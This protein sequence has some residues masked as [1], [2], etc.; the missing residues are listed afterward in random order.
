M[1]S[2]DL[3]VTPVVVEESR[4]EQ[5]QRVTRSVPVVAGHVGRRNSLERE[6]LQSQRREAVERLRLQAE[7]RNAR[8]AA[9]RLPKDLPGEVLQYSH[10][11]VSTDDSDNGG[12][13]IS[14][15]T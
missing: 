14:P 6:R 13:G 10:V 2:E 11:E 15:H 9:R 7:N 4:V 3:G 5:S 1:G 12:G 8:F